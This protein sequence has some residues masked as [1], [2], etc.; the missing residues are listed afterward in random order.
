MS[1][2][3]NTHTR[4]QVEKGCASVSQVL[5]N[6]RWHWIQIV[7]RT[8]RVQDQLSSTCLYSGP[9]ISIH[10]KLIIKRENIPEFL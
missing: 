2:P 8:G 3:H 1:P 10:S 4:T 9:E 5:T 6:C 7:T